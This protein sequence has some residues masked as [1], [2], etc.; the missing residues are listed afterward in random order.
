VFKGWVEEAGEDKQLD[1]GVLEG[2]YSRHND[3]V[4]PGSGVLK[5]G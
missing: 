5:A 3:M 2:V 4:G 1:L